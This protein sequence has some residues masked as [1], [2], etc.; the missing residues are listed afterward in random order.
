MQEIAL[1]DTFLCSTGIGKEC[2][3]DVIVLVLPMPRSP[4][5]CILAYV[6]LIWP[7]MDALQ[8]KLS[9]PPPS[10]SLKVLL[11]LKWMF[12]C[13]EQAVNTLSTRLLDKWMDNVLPVKSVV[14]TLPT[15]CPFIVLLLL[16]PAPFMT[17]KSL[18]TQLTL[19]TLDTQW[20]P[21]IMVNTSMSISK[22][23]LPN[24]ALSVNS[25]WPRELVSAN[26][27]MIKWISLQDKL[28]TF[29]LYPT[30]LHVLA[31]IPHLSLLVSKL[32]KISII[33]W[34]WIPLTTQ[35]W[36]LIPQYHIPLPPHHTIL[37][38]DNSSIGPLL[39]EILCTIS[40]QLLI[41]WTIWRVLNW[42]SWSSIFLS[43]F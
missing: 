17:C 22:V 4:S 43:V 30:E 15:L 14:V 39:I 32:L 18:L 33:N 37:I 29:C 25:D 9:Q 10:T 13:K 3:L 28:I 5:L 6:T 24:R 1:L 2:P 38:K 11:T 34:I 8:S 12:A 40:C 26:Y 7:V 19:P 27:T 23:L 42:Q 36:H 41:L 35:E 20:S 21:L 31:T 16:T